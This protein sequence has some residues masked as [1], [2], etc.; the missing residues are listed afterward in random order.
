LGKGTQQAAQ[1]ADQA[2]KADVVRDLQRNVTGN[3]A[4]EEDRRPVQKHVPANR[5]SPTRP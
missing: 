3:A 2:V 5:K 1:R 4:T